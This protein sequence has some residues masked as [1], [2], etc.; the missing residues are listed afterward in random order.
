MAETDARYQQLSSNPDVVKVFNGYVQQAEVA[1][2]RRVQEE[3]LV[4]TGDLLNSFRA[5]AATAAQG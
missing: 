5:T 2:R 3:H 4:L 1:F